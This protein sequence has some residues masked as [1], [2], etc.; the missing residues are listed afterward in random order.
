MMRIVKCKGEAF[1]LRKVFRWSVVFLILLMLL[2]NACAIRHLP[3]DPPPKK[4]S[5]AMEPARNGQLATLA[6]TLSAK[7]GQD[8]SAFLLIDRNDEA[9]RWRLMLADLATQ[10]IDVQYFLWYDDAVGNLFA[11]RIYQA[12]ER[13]VRV[14][15]LVD[16]IVMLD[17]DE[18]IATLSLHPN[19]DISIFNPWLGRDTTVGRGFE[20]ADVYVRMKTQGG[21]IL[22]VIQHQ[23]II[24]KYPNPHAPLCRLIDP[25]GK[26]ITHRVV[27]P[28]EVLDIDGLG[29]QIRQHQ[30]PSQGFVIMVD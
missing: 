14:R 20:Y 1:V 4:I 30:A 3:K 24:H 15:I 21:N 11:K 19:I 13:G 2:L 9:L 26:Q 18:D 5:Y 8:T 16:D 22:V 29:R 28:E 12:A 6:N 17:D 23:D 7:F 27:V 10:S 25:L